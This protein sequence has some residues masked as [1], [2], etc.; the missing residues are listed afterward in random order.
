MKDMASQEDDLVPQLGMS[1]QTID[2]AWS[3]WRNYGG[4]KDFGVRR[5]MIVRVKR[6]Y[7]YFKGFFVLQRRY[8][9]KR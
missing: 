4:K 3:F 6:W 2:E 8:T 9:R 5:A 1:F 7:N